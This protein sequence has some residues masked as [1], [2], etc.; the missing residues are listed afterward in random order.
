MSTLSTSKKTKQWISHHVHGQ[1]SLV[2]MGTKL[3]K[4]LNKRLVWIKE[5]SFYTEKFSVSYSGFTNVQIMPPG[6]IMTMDY[7][8]D[9]VLVHV[10]AQGKVVQ[11]PTVG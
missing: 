4:Q 9:R 11:A 8:T 6:S 2:E 10:D 3:L 1:I 5:N 7:R